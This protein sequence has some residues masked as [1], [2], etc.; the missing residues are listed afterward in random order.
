MTRSSQAIRPFIFLSLSIAMLSLFPGTINLARAEGFTGTVTVGVNP[1]GIGVDTSLNRIYVS[2]YGNNGTFPSTVSVLNGANNSLIATILVGVSPAGVAVNS[3][4]HRVYIAN[5]NSS[6]VSVINGVTNAVIAN[7]TVGTH[8]SRIALNPATGEIYVTNSGDDTVSRINGTT[9]TLVGNIPVGRR[10]TGIA[11]LSSTNTIYVTNSLDGTAS[12]IDGKTHSVIKTLQVGNDPGNIA[13]D[14][15]TNLVYLVNSNS[16]NGIVTLING[17]SNTLATTIGVGIFPSG[18]DVNQVTNKISIIDGFTLT[19]I[20]TVNLAFGTIPGVVG[21]N[22]VTNEIYVANGNRKT[23]SVLSGHS[24]ST[25][26]A[27]NPSTLSPNESTTCTG[28][29]TDLSGSGASAPTGT[30]FFSSSGQGSFNASSC[31]LGG[32]GTTTTCFVS[33]SPT[34]FGMGPQTIFATYGG[35]ATHMSSSGQTVITLTGGTVG[36]TLIPTNKFGYSTY[37]VTGTLMFYVVI[38]S[39]ILY[40][41]RFQEGEGSMKDDQ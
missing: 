34:G 8:P 27:C 30:V 6:N 24:T 9:N 22:T 17:T 2:N 36:G 15:I 12:V 1:D 5:Y 37:F 19:V 31:T 14:S 10:P 25:G 7:V 28:T 35:D 4:S 16:S 23:L 13:S 41:R 29:V 3:A 38:I 32:T 40:T 39:I 21:V 11:L 26:L 20:D 18:I 33:Y